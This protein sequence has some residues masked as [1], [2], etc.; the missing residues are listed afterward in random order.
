MDGPTACSEY[1]DKISDKLNFFIM[2]AIQ[3][4]SEQR[5][6]SFRLIIGIL[7]GKETV[8]FEQLSNHVKWCRLF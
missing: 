8:K 2:K 1:N 4:D 5:W 3:L 7:E 6:H